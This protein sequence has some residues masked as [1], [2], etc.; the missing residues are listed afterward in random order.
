[1]KKKIFFITGGTGSF[2]KKFIQYLLKKKLAKKII[3]FSRDEFKQ[4]I[5]QENEIIKKINQY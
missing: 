1:M 4:F 2:A 5:M 3:I